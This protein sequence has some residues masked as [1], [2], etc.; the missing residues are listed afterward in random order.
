MNLLRLS[1]ICICFLQIPLFSN[2]LDRNEATIE[3]LKGSEVIP[4]LSKLAELRLSFF[5]NY[6]YLYEGNLRDEEEYLTMYARSE[7]SVFGVV[8]EGEEI[9]GLVTG[10]PLLECH[11][12][13]KNPWI[14]HEDPNVFYLGEIVLS[15]RYQT[16]DL[17]EKLYR[18]FENVV[19]AIGMHDAIVV[20]EI[21][22][23]EE[24][25]KKTENELSSE[26]LWNGRGFIRHPEISGYFSWKEIGDLEESDH[27][28]VYWKKP[29]SS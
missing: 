26:V 11:E 3:V 16:T 8:K 12:A 17:Q 10:L 19:K 5:R 18:Q 24:D 14:Q 28:M 25:L 15:E 27:L 21:E 4:Y 23:K 6:P 20:C 22:R 2:N 7:N 1:L 13:H 9:V 29:L